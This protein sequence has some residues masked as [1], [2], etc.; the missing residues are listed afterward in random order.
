MDSH[1]SEVDIDAFT[2]CDLKHINDKI[3][4][5]CM[6]SKVEKFYCSA[7]CFIVVSVAILGFL[8][9]FMYYE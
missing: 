7:L 9:M 6:K 2:K 8:V 3:G 1:S 4:G 5:K